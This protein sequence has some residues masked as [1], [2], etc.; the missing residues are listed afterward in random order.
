[1]SEL[2]GQLLGMILVLT[3]FGVLTAILVPS[4]KKA[5]DSVGEQVA[6]DNEG[7][8]ETI[9]SARSSFHVAIV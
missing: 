5:A 1:M 4:F 8:V 9:K 2:K 7:N 3:I 6:V